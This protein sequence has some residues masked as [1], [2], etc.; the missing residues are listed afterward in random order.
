MIHKDKFSL[1]MTGVDVSAQNDIA[2]ALHKYLVNMMHCLL[3]K[4]NLGP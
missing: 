3:N 2:E 1:E 4:S